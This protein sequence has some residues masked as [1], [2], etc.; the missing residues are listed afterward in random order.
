MINGK[1]KIEVGKSESGYFIFEKDWV[2]RDGL[3]KE[4]FSK[5]L[6]KLHDKYPD[7]EIKI[8]TNDF[9]GWL[10]ETVNKMKWFF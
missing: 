9:T 1:K 5:C 3:S 10:Q 7:Y 6:S 8:T 2:V 4:E